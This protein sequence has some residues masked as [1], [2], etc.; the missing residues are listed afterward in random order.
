MAADTSSDDLE[1]ST[2]A[3]IAA[4]DGDAHAAVRALLVANCYLEAEVE[5]L[6]KA[7]SRG[8]VRGRRSRPPGLTGTPRR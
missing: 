4:C 3:V 6:E 1:A 5:R 8:Y 2:E 7:V